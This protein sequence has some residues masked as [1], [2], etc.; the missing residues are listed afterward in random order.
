MW[1]FDRRYQPSLGDRVYFSD[2]LGLHPGTLVA[3][4]SD[5]IFMVQPDNQYAEPVQ[6]PRRKIRPMPLDEMKTF[7]LPHFVANKLVAMGKPNRYA[8]P[9]PIVD[10][11]WLLL[12][13]ASEAQVLD[14]LRSV[15]QTFVGNDPELPK[16]ES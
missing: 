12:R 15:R 9:D 6:C 10:E 5:R 1:P 16:E 2:T 7:P 13:Y 4:M 14:L 3:K 11:V 8:I